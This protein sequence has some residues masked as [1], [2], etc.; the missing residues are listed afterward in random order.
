MDPVAY[1]NRPDM[2]H[3]VLVIAFTGWNDAGNAASMAV[4]YLTEQLIATKFAS[5][6]PEEFYDFSIQRPQVRLTKGTQRKIQWPFFFSVC[7]SF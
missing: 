4:R 7:H 1:E 2:K 3:P 6:D 5:I